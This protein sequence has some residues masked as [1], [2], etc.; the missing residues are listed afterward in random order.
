MSERERGTKE[1]QKGEMEGERQVRS[2][3]D[4]KEGK[5]ERRSE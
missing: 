3:S 4:V 5:R 1:R 2:Q